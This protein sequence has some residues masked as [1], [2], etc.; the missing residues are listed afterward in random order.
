M[1][2]EYWKF[3]L[4]ADMI[5]IENELKKNRLK[6]ATNSAERMAKAHQVYDIK[7]RSHANEK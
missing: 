5:G 3:E 6:P 7:P 4:P 1:E 2:K